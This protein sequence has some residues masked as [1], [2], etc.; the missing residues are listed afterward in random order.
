[1]ISPHES[2][3]GNS[4]QHGEDGN[5]THVTVKYGTHY[6]RATIVAVELT[7]KKLCQLVP[8]FRK[9]R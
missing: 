6:A 1:M 8:K 9:V 2:R 3:V 5:Y 7:D 4:S